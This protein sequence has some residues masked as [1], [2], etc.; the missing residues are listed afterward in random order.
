M[1]NAD[2]RALGTKEGLDKYSF[3]FFFF[4][5]SKDMDVTRAKELVG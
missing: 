4:E 1:L 2:N 5:R 3:Y